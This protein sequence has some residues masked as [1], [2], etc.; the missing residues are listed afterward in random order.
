VS[1]AFSDK[2]R[3][4]FCINHSS[5]LLLAHEKKA[6]YRPRIFCRLHRADIGFGTE[7][8]SLADFGLFG[9]V[10]RVL[11]PGI[12]EASR[13]WN[14][15]RALS[16]KAK[17][18]ISLVDFGGGCIGNVVFSFFQNYPKVGLGLGLVDFPL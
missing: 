13:P 8:S 17:E 14:G 18:A 15:R 6:D 7:A 1:C 9:H 16:S 3:P 10:V 4:A 11:L 5:T 12:L 2:N